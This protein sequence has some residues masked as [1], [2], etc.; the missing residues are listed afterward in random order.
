[1]EDKFDEEKVTIAILNKKFIELN[2]YNTDTNNKELIDYNY[3]VDML[4]EEHRKKD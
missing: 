1:M 4:D 2:K 3:E